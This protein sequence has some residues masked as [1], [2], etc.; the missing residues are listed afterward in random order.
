MTRTMFKCYLGVSLFGLIFLIYVACNFETTI[1]HPYAD[2]DAESYQNFTAAEKNN[3]TLILE[4]TLPV[5]ELD[6]IYL[7]FVTYHHE[8]K[9]FTDGQKIYEL[10]AGSNAFGSTTGQ[11]WNFIKLKNEYRGKNLRIE[12]Y[13][14]YGEVRE[15]DIYIGG[16]VALYRKIFGDNIFSYALCL[17]MILLGIIMIVYWCYVRL[18][19]YIPGGMLFLG[20]F[21]VMLGIWSI[22]E[23]PIQI[24]VFQNHVVSSYLAFVSIMLLP[25][26][27]LMFIKDLYHEKNS[28]WW[29]VIGYISLGNVLLC[30]G[31]QIFHVADLKQSIWITHSVFILFAFAMGVF[32]VREIRRGTLS[33]KVK[34]N[35]ICI[36]LDLIGLILDMVNYYFRWYGD[37]NLFGRLFFLIHIVVLGW[38]GMKESANLMKLGKQAEIY[39]KLA[40]R[41]ALTELLNRTAFEKDLEERT[42]MEE[43]TG[44]LMMDL[45]N[46]KKYNDNQGHDAGDRYIKTASEM[47]RSIFGKAGKC[48]RIGGDEFCVVSSQV[49]DSYMNILIE[50]LNEE[51]KKYNEMNPMAK[52][53]IA[54]GYAKFDRK[55][56][57]DLNDTRKRADSRMYQ[58]KKEMKE[59]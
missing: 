4:N 36:M 21:A 46:L 11:V 10:K 52:I 1:F 45:N 27:F 16:K 19:T 38:V 30:I 12:L 28:P 32:T 44:I 41:D 2:R 25:V 5:Y 58:Y 35:I 51:E 17:L 50:E 9:V 56:D 55:Q 54:C 49:T 47:I 14:P 15:P 39:E 22:N 6:D 13:S 59:G 48:Y 18:K 53:G 31:L 20:M 34:V 8:L 43:G 23:I 42:G 7:G 40:Y 26:P 29:Y 3:S 24:L 33:M 37:T 57:A